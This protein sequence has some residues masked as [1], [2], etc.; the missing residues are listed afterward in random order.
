[1]KLF[2]ASKI[3]RTKLFAALIGLVVL[4]GCG[5]SD[6]QGINDDGI[7]DDF[8]PNLIQLGAKEDTAYAPTTKGYIAPCKTVRDRLSQDS[9]FHFYL[10]G[11]QAG[12]KVYFEMTVPPAGTEGEEGAGFWPYV[13]VI[14]PNNDEKGAWGW[15][16]LPASSLST[17]VGWELPVKGTYGILVSSVGNMA[18]LGGKLGHM[19]GSEG[20]YELKINAK[21]RCD[22][23]PEGQEACPYNLECRPTGP[24]PG[25]CGDCTPEQEA[26]D[27]TG[28]CGCMYSWCVA[29]ES[30]DDCDPRSCYPSPAAE[31]KDPL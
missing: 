13:R 7:P 19:P 12:W 22:N 21:L 5:G 4:G 16:V 11:A 14:A 2:N 17:S 1:M 28:A 20:E 9:G 18:F 10:F 31:Y 6:N 27:E 25:F 15:S 30:P 3:L 29:C 24:V 23:V 8:D 26:Q